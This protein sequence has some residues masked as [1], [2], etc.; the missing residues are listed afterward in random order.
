MFTF[1][2]SKDSTDNILNS[3]AYLQ[4]ELKQVEPHIWANPSLI[5]ALIAY[6]MADEKLR[7]EYNKEM[8]VT[9]WKN[10]ARNDVTKQVNAFQREGTIMVNHVRTCCIPCNEVITNVLTA[11][12]AVE[13]RNR[14]NTAAWV[15]ANTGTLVHVNF[16]DAR[17]AQE[18]EEEPRY[19]GASQLHASRFSGCFI[20]GEDGHFIRDCNVSPEEA[21]CSW[22]KCKGK[23]HL[24]KACR[25]K[26]A[27][28]TTTPHLPKGQSR[29]RKQG[30]SRSE[31]R[32][33]SSS[34]GRK[35]KEGRG[36][37][38]EKKKGGS[39]TKPKSKS[40]SKSSDSR[41]SS[42]ER[43]KNG[44]KAGEKVAEVNLMEDEE[45]QSNPEEEYAE[46]YGTEYESES[47]PGKCAQI[48][49]SG[50]MK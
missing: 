34:P 3:H 44:R 32:G 23:G 8:A 42:K 14:S 17:S 36:R 9:P 26:I 40:R 28:E 4:E 1:D 45:E 12:K 38:T 16:M 15:K 30:R 11:R 5:P 31:T 47:V 18:E 37:N 25:K 29:E 19:K 21:R 24:V 50:E 48:H 6:S 13:A 33:Q 20:C 7:E 27:S 22:S 49:K 2:G 10:E 35:P 46:G 39:Q 41:K 43:K